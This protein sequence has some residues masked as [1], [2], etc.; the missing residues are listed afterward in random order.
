[1]SR[2]TIFF[3]CLRRQ[4]AP[5]HLNVRPKLTEVQERGLATKHSPPNIKTLDYPPTKKARVVANAPSGIDEGVKE[6]IIKSDELTDTSSAPE[7]HPLG[8][9][10]RIRK[11][12]QQLMKVLTLSIV[13]GR[14][15]TTREVLT[16]MD[17][18]FPSDEETTFMESCGDLLAFDIHD[19]LDIYS[20]ETLFLATFGTLGQGGAGQLC[21]YTWDKILIPLDVLE[22]KVDPFENV[23]DTGDLKRII[24]WRNSVEPGLEDTKDKEGDV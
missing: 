16:L 17:T 24:G 10:I 11:S 3:A 5:L 12:C 20:Q 7:H 8:H 4:R 1:M 6:E 21:Q 2:G 15:P 19:A 22:T 13:S 14:L 18:E 9:M 23:A